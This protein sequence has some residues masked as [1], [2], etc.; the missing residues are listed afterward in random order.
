MKKIFGILFFAFCVMNVSAQSS[1]ETSSLGKN[2][3]GFSPI[4]ITAIN[5]VDEQEADIC[6][7]VSYERIAANEVF[8]FK[9]PVTFSL[10]NQYYYFMPMLKIYPFKQGVVKY[11]IGPQFYFATGD[12]KHKF[13]YYDYGYN[14]DTTITKSRTQLGFMI[15]HCLNFTIMQNLYMGVEASLGINYYDSNAEDPVI[16]PYYHNSTTT[17]SQFYPAFHFNFSMGYRF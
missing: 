16:D 2:I 12:I 15:T 14:P 1:T 3:I 8:G 6:I 17:D 10:K 7:N 4:Q 13:S 11:A 5:P 9:L